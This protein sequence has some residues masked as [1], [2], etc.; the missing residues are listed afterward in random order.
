MQAA[1]TLLPEPYYSKVSH[2][3]DLLDRQFGLHYVN[4]T[5]F[6]HFTWQLGESYQEAELLPL[7]QR[8]MLCQKP[9]EVTTQGL[10]HFPGEAPVLFIEIHNPPAL[11]KLHSAL[12]E[13]LTP[14]TAEPSLLYSPKTWQPHITLASK[15][16]SWEML[17]EVKAFLQ[18]EDLN[19][20]FSADNLA[21]A[22]QNAEGKTQVGHIFRFGKGLTESFDFGSA[23][24]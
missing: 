6:P 4:V 12:W 21:I 14:L 7:L 11:R 9:F 20:R 5:P 2:L 13:L 19:W 8:F 22:F 10:A 16:L 15:D 3:W 24:F 1:L 23:D 18:A 17:D